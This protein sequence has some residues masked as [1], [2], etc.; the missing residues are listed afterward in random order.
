MRGVQV[1]PER[2]CGG[3]RGERARRRIEPGVM[4]H[5]ENAFPRRPREIGLE[6]QLLSGAHRGRH[7]RV[8]AVQHHDVPRPDVDAV[9]AEAARPGRGAKVV[10]RAV[11][12]AQAVIVVADGRVGA[13]QLPPPGGCVTVRKIGARPAW[14]RVVATR[15]DGPGDGVQNARRLDAAGVIAVGDVSAEQHHLRARRHHAHRERVR[16]GPSGAV[17]DRHAHAVE[18]ERR[19]GVAGGDRR[20]RARRAAGSR[21]AVAPLD[22]VAP[23]GVVRARVAERDREVDRGCRI[24]REIRTSVHGRRGWRRWRRRARGAV[25][26][27][28]ARVRELGSRDRD[29]LP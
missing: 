4:P 27:G 24:R 2:Q 20:G 29:E 22:R 6:P 28:R 12:V 13:E 26:R 16:S 18:A 25:A 3:A 8:V 5:R 17:G 23:W 21:R 9:V 1:V 7:E 14:V 10:P 19:V 11:R 15:D